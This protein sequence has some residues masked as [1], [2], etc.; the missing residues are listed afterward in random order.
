MLE[1]HMHPNW[2]YKNLVEDNLPWDKKS[3][4]RLDDFLN[5]YTLHDSIWIGIFHHLAY[6]NYITLAFKWDSF[7]LPNEIIERSSQV[8]DWPYL[9]VQLDKVIEVTTTNFSDID[10]INRAIGSSETIQLEG[11]TQLAID[12]VFGGQV[13]ISFKGTPSILAL[14]AKGSVLRI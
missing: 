8:A 3:G 1:N 6:A 10:G 4:Y 9:F 5:K 11:V 12:D 7:W 13:T 2:L 14:T